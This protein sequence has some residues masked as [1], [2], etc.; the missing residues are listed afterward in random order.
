MS[1]RSELRNSTAIDKP[2][3]IAAVIASLEMS[4]LKDNGDEQAQ[5]NKPALGAV[6]LTADS[7]CRYL[8]HTS[9]MSCDEIDALISELGCLREKLVADGGRLE[10]A[11]MDFA[12][13][14]QSVIQ[15]TELSFDGFAHV[16]A[17]AE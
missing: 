11:I 7:V 8:Q 15:L 10:Q 13:F 9:A 17:P 1:S 4:D 14:N 3:G 5:A 16:K 12:T 2:L 6:E